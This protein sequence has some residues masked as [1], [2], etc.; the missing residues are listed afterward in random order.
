MATIST[1]PPIPPRTP[2]LAFWERR[3]HHVAREPPNT[4]GSLASGFGRAC[5]ATCGAAGAGAPAA[6]ADGFAVRT[7]WQWGHICASTGTLWPHRSHSRV[8]CVLAAAGIGASS[9]PRPLPLGTRRFRRQFGQ[10]ITAPA[11]SASATML[12][13]QGHRNTI[14]MVPHPLCYSRAAASWLQALSSVK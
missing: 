2:A 11:R 7:V 13:P 14:A 8:L 9:T 3:V 6:G 12:R 1:K 4:I 10:T 5:G